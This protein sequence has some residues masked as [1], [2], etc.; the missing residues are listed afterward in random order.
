[1]SRE[2]LDYLDDIL[3]NA[4][5]ACEFANG[6]TADAFAADRKTLVVPAN[7]Q[8]VGKLGAHYKNAALGDVSVQRSGTKTLF[9]FGEWQ[10]EVATKKNPDG[11]VSF[12]TI[13][14]GM[15]GIDLVAGT[16]NDRRSL[17]LRDAQHE[18]VFVEK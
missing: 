2:V 13:V 4:L 16:A 10:S 5:A 3:E 8:E 11:S 18:Y 1:M 12:V 6:L 17:T 14:P 9:D 7:A 15:S